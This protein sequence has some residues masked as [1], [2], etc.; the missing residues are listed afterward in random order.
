MKNEMTDLG[1]VVREFNDGFDTHKVGNV[2]RYIRGSKG[3]VFFNGVQYIEDIPEVI[4]I[5]D[6]VIKTLEKR[7]VLNKVGAIVKSR[8]KDFLDV[9]TYGNVKVA[10]FMLD[11]DLLGGEIKFLSF[12]VSSKAESYELLQNYIDSYDPHLYY[13]VKFGISSKIAL[14]VNTFYSNLDLLARIK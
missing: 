1:F 11:S 12:A 3:E 4:S 10:Y 6:A 14:V 13:G 5:Q 9:H 2:K 7:G 8:A